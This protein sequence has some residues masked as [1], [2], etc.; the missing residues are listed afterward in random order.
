[1]SA[2][3]D[4]LRPHATAIGVP[5]ASSGL[6]LLDHEGGGSRWP[7]PDSPSLGVPL[8]ET[9]SMEDV[10]EV[11]DAS[12]WGCSGVF[13][14]LALRERTTRH[15]GRLRLL[16][17]ESRAAVRERQGLTARGA[18]QLRRRPAVGADRSL[19]TLQLG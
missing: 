5:A 8:V 3:H 4:P 14:L 1:M 9:W 18:W 17:G 19:I 13:S 15:V 16:A 12:P 10:D 2:P 7:P 6:Q 11:G